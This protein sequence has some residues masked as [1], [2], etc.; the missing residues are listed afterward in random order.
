DVYKRQ[1]WTG[2]LTSVAE[3]ISK[4]QLEPGDILLFHNAKDPENGSHVTLFGGWTD[5]N[6]THYI[7]YEQARPRTRKQS[8]PM[9]YWNN[10]DRYVAYRYK[11]LGAGTPGSGSSTAFPG[12]DQ[13]GP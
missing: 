8:T 9:A 6:R 7:A 1:E 3:R 4:D 5:Y 2:S 10:S 12:A 11:G 13:F